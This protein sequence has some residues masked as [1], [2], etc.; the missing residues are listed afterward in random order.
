MVGLG[1]AH[2]D[3]SEQDRMFTEEELWAV[4]KDLPSDKAPGPD[5][6]IGLFFQKAWEVIKADLM[7]AIS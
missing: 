2:V 1:V 7:A 3:L 5:G 4:I 6:F